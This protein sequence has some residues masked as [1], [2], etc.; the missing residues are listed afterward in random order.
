MKCYRSGPYA[1]FPCNGAPINVIERLPRG[2]TFLFELRGNKARFFPCVNYLAVK[3]ESESCVEPNESVVGVKWAITPASG[4]VAQS[5]IPSLSKGKKYLGAPS[6]ANAF[7]LIDDEGNVTFKHESI[8]DF[9]GVD[10]S[11]GMFAFV[12]MEGRLF[13]VEEKNFKLKVININTDYANVVKFLQDGILLCKRKCA[14]LSS[15]GEVMWE[16]EVGWVDNVPELVFNYVLIPDADK[17]SIVVIDIT[18]GKRIR[19]V[20]LDSSVRAVKKCGKNVFVLTTDAL[21][22]L[23]I[24]S[25]K[26][27]SVLDVVEGWSLDCDESKLVI[28]ER[29]G[30]VIIL[31]PDASGIYTTVNF[32]EA[33]SSFL[34]SRLTPY[35]GPHG[36][37]VDG[38]TVYLSLFRGIIMALHLHLRYPSQ[39][40]LSRKQ[41][42]ER[43]PIVKWIKLT[44]GVYYIEPNYIKEMMIS[45]SFDHEWI[46]KAW[47]AELCAGAP[48]WGF[49]AFDNF[50]DD[51]VKAIRSG[52]APPPTGGWLLRRDFF[53]LAY[54]N[55]S[56]PLSKRAKGVVLLQGGKER[57]DVCNK[58][59]PG[60]YVQLIKQLKV[61]N[62][63]LLRVRVAALGG[64]STVEKALTGKDLF[65]DA[66]A[67]IKVI[68]NK[69][70]EKVVYLGGEDPGW[71]VIEIP[72]NG[73]GDRI[74]IILSSE[75]G[76][77][78]RAC[79]I[80]TGTWDYE[81]IGYDWVEVISKDGRTLF[82][83]DFVPREDPPT[84]IYV[85]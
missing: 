64:Y 25:W 66:Y 44:D 21:L 77:S 17:G 74:T 29:V 78:V 15:K 4:K 23:N 75:S 55:P 50:P 3:E 52:R 69:T 84:V 27:V 13:L 41:G 80:C 72:L 28:S 39:V 26:P 8:S 58:W 45:L 82:K 79:E 9:T 63:Y 11:N 83:E 40:R 81:F 49:A 12:E 6:S 5:L 16:E 56:S 2:A 32:S 51:L 71:K 10:Y 68:G 33:M 37:T 20:E 76:G 48:A 60:G 57:F 61:R 18:N 42:A 43:K 31:K 36:L 70:V 62:A 24:Q 46:V 30:N 47:S 34:S 14:M 53:S 85:K 22:S 19:E 1:L 38:N 73:L 35:I 7:Y 65:F 54:E 59:T 67:V